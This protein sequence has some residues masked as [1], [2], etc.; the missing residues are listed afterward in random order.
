MYDTKPASD[1]FARHRSR[2]DPQAYAQERVGA[3]MKLVEAVTAAATKDG[4]YDVSSMG[5][6]RTVFGLRGHG[7][8]TLC[9]NV[10]YINLLVADRRV[11]IP[12]EYDPGTKTFVGKDSETFSTN[13]APPQRRNAVTVIAETIVAEIDKLARPA[14]PGISFNLPGA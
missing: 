13:G 5:T 12:I 3:V 8:V 10:D 14:K 6:D 9:F 11:E 1:V 4:R 7:Q 2:L